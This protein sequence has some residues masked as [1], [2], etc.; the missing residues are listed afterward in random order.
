M[1]MSKFASEAA[2]GRRMKSRW[3]QEMCSSFHN[4]WKENIVNNLIQNKAMFGTCFFQSKFCEE[5]GLYV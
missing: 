4:E 2:S 1:S 5:K 3:E